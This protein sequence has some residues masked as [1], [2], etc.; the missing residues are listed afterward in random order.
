LK[1][2]ETREEEKIYEQ[3]KDKR[4][5]IDLEEEQRRKR[6]RELEQEQRRVKMNRL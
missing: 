1:K 3:E 4:K 6:G 2:T 5:G